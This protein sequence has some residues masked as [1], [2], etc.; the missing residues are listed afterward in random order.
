MR[1]ILGMAAGLLLVVAPSTQAAAV[2][3]GATIKQD[4][5]LKR[6]LQNCPGNGL[7]VA[8]RGVVLDLNGHT[9]DGT[10]GGTGILVSGVKRV[11]VKNGRVTDFEQGV[12]FD[13][14]PK[15]FVKRVTSSE[16]QTRAFYVNGSDETVLKKNVGSATDSNAAFDLR[17]STGLTLVDNKA[18]NN[19]TDGFV[20]L[21]IDS[22]RVEGNSAD[23]NGRNA[24]TVIRATSLQILGN[25][26]TGSGSDG[27]WLPAFDSDN[28]IRGNR[29][30]DNGDDGIDAEQNNGSNN[31]VASNTALNNDDWGIIVGSG[32]VDGGGNVASGNGQAAQ[33]SGVSCTTS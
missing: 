16:N 23:A 4:T 2:E 14:A 25:A 33:C 11:T 27:L 8:K 9:V 18:D 15:G 6:D 32:D 31:T 3:C 20:L 13:Q 22:S 19:A 24:F 10:G 21:G 12:A 7:V 29:V 17:D 1:R 28:V 30:E 5:V 26:A